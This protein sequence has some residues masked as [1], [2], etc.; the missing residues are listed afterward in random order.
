MLLYVIFFIAIVVMVA[1][2]FCYL[3]DEFKNKK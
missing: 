2:V 1:E 3:A